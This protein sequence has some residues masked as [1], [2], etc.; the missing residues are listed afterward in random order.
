MCALLLCHVQLFCDPV[1][2]TLPG[3]SV[4]DICQARILER[5]VISFSKGSSQPRDQIPHLLHLLHWQ[6][7]SL[8]LSPW[9]ALK[10]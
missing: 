9:E 6:A 5:V 8:P 10:G 2:C 4:Q 7:D 3:S 1:D